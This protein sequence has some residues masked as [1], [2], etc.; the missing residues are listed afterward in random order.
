MSTTIAGTPPQNLRRVHATNAAHPA[1]GRKTTPDTDGVPAHPARP[2]QPGRTG[3]L[4]ALL[5]AVA[6]AGLALHVRTNLPYT[7]ASDLGY[8][9]GAAGATL[10]AVLLLYSVR[11]RVRATAALGPVRH[12]FRFHM[13]AGITGPVLVLFHSTFRVGSF[14]AAVALG[15]MLLVATS[16]LV[17]RFLYRR[18]HHGLYGREA[19]LRELE[20]ALAQQLDALDSQ[21]AALPEVRRSVEGYLVLVRARHASGARRVLH[22][23]GLGWRRRR[24]NHRLA[25]LLRQLPDT[26]RA[27]A[28][29]LAAAQGAAQFSVWLR[30]FA[31]WHVVHIPFLGML[32]LTAIAHVIAVH[33][34]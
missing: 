31:L 8:W 17:G 5:A 23:L 4:L 29:T 34:Y 28:A 13:V 11:K 10:M 26:R 1:P 32:V 33:A 7:S 18:I 3:P 30:L 14:N 16:G 15:S 19:T 27:V 25:P 2:N 21:L 12:W 9:M 20:A 24:I 6:T 22:F